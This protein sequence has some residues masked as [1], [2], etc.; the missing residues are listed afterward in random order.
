LEGVVELWFP[1]LVVP[2]VEPV[3]LGVDG[4]VVVVFGFAVVFGTFAGWAGEVG[5]GVAVAGGTGAGVVL[6]GAGGGVA[7]A[8]ASGTAGFFDSARPGSLTFRAPPAVKP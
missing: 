6:A 3:E 7:L 5:G 1:P 8:T 2:P 4:V